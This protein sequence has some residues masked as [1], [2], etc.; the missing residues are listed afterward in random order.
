MYR[1]KFKGRLFNA[2]AEQSPIFSQISEVIICIYGDIV[3]KMMVNRFCNAEMNDILL[4][5]S[6]RYIHGRYRAMRFD[7]GIA[8]SRT[9]ITLIRR[10]ET[11][12]ADSDRAGKWRVIAFRER[13]RERERETERQ[14]ERE[15][16]R[17]REEGS[18][19]LGCHRSCT[20]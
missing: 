20:M 17:E 3:M 4:F 18:R 14:R 12:R 16:E 8:A 13:E 15:R 7:T 6:R 1:V 10:K 5:S 11:D 19:T 9:A 2:P